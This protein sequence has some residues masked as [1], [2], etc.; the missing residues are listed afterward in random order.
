MKAG[1]PKEPDIAIDKMAP[2]LQDVAVDLFKVLD[3]P[4]CAGLVLFPFQVEI[5][6]LPLPDS[7]TACAAKS[8]ALRGSLILVTAIKFAGKR[9]DSG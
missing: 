4:V 8:A 5:E 7:S 3:D 6:P 9:R 2:A 1:F